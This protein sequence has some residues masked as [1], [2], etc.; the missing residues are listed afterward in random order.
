M[1]A[2]GDRDREQRFFRFEVRARA[3]RPGEARIARAAARLYGW[4]SNYGASI[5]RP[6]AWLGGVILFFAAL[7]G[8]IGLWLG[9]LEVAPSADGVWQALEVSMATSFRPFFLFDTPR[10]GTGGF[11]G[12]VLRRGGG[13]ATLMRLLG[14]LQSVA[15]ILLLFLVGLA[16]KRKFQIG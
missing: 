1:A 5:G 14:V 6:I 15:S 4:T 12:E 3:R 16:L 9:L 2:Q 11:W 8:A 13:A 7:H 10:P